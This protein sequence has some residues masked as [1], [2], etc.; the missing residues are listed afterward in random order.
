MDQDSPAT[1]ESTQASGP[2]PPTEQAPGPAGG[3]YAPQGQTAYGYQ[4]APPAPYTPPAAPPEPAPPAP[5]IPPAAPAE[6][7]TAPEKTGGR[8]RRVGGIILIALGVIFL[9]QYYFPGFDMGVLVA[10]LLIVI[11]GLLVFRGGKS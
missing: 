1:D 4:P 8:G 11:G 3:Q 6:P 2:P 9:A 7:Q 5:Y 10:V